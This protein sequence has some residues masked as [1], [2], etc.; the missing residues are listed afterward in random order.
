MVGCR[1]AERNGEVVQSQWKCICFVSVCCTLHIYDFQVLAQF[2]GFK[3]FISFSKYVC[4]SAACMEL[5]R[6]GTHACSSGIWHTL[7]YLAV[8]YEWNAV[9]CA[10]QQ[11]RQLNLNVI[12]LLTTSLSALCGYSAWREMARWPNCLRAHFLRRT[13]L[14]NS[15]YIRL[16][17]T[18]N[19]CATYERR[20]T[21]WKFLHETSP[22]L[23]RL[24]SRVSQRNSVRLRLEM[25]EVWCTPSDFP[26]LS[27]AA[28]WY[29]MAQSRSATAT[30]EPQS[31]ISQLP[32][33]FNEN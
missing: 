27:E 11:S 31:H 12:I 5:C 22:G 16:L 7:T 4:C 20:K 28:I 33:H 2:T 15:P 3:K 14:Y 30:H 21:F 8:N 18:K 10:S 1:E 29:E 23:G 13:K 19:S 26:A 25:T 17:P 24:E 32:L 9:H 6:I